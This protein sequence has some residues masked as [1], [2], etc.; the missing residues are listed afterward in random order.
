MMYISKNGKTITTW[1][2]G[3][4]LSWSPNETEKYEVAADGDEL[5]A[6][7]KLLGRSGCPPLHHIF[8]GDSALEIILNIQYRY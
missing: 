5:Y 6:I 3:E 4:R 8:V 2:T 1:H 7:W